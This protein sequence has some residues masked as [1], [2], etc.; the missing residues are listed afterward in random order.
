MHTIHDNKHKKHD[1][2][3]TIHNTMCIIRYTMHT[4]DKHSQYGRSTDLQGLLPG[5][6]IRSSSAAASASDTREHDPEG[7]HRVLGI[8][9]IPK[10]CQQFA[11]FPL[12]L[13]KQRPRERDNNPEVKR[14]RE[15]GREVGREGD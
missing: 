9:V 4:L 1:T 5:L 2:M 3:H 13:Q 10:C 7:V 12:L 8:R 6:T 14:E 15:G 11:A